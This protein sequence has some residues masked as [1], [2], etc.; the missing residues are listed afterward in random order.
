MRET[1]VAVFKVVQFS[2]Q[3]SLP[4]HFVRA[5]WKREG[6]QRVPSLVY[7]RQLKSH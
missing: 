1:R 4:F 2:I 7:G 5:T 3:I 6:F